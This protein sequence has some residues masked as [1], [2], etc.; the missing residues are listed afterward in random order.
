MA[1]NLVK[2][3]GLNQSQLDDIQRL[4]DSCN[5]FEGLTMKL[6]WNHLQQRPIHE[7]NDF[8]YYVEDKLV[9]Y[10]ALYIFHSQE[11]E[12]S[13]MTAPGY[14]RQ[15]IFKQLLAVAQQEVAGRA[16]P[17]ILFICERISP[18]VTSTMQAIGAQ[19]DFSEYKMT[20]QQAIKPLPLPVNLSLRPVQAED[21]TALSRMDELCFNMPAKESASQYQKDLANPWRDMS[22]ITLNGQAIGKIRVSVGIGETYIGGFCLLPEQRGRGYGKAIL[23]HLTVQLAEAS[24]HPIVLEVAVH[25]ERALSLYTGCGFAISTAFDYYRLAV[26]PS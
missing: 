13:A 17:K 1:H 14:R 10:L 5:Q 26:N 7:M 21:I 8:L 20:L 18:A 22:V 3:H 6:N 12:I 23:S 2:S 16:I 11:V 25:N 19:Y 4:A 24:H 15:N 9:G